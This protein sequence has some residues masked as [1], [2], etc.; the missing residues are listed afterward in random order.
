MMLRARVVF[1][2]L[3]AAAA[4]VPPAT[5][6]QHHRRGSSLS[7]IDWGRVEADAVLA[8]VG[9]SFGVI[10]TL[11]AY[12]NRRYH[13]RTRV[14]CAYCEGSGSLKCGAC[15]ATPGQVLVD[16]EAIE[17]PQ[18]GGTAKVKCVNCE[19]TG[20]AIPPQLERKTHAL[21]DEELETKL[22]Q[23]GIAALA[24]DILRQG[25]SQE[26]MEQFNLLVSRR[27]ETIARRA[28]KDQKTPEEDTDTPPEEEKSIP[29]VAGGRSGDDASEDRGDTP[30]VVKEP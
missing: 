3:T 20:L 27:A 24:G 13:A 7:A 19:A 6:Q 9:G 2:V 25:P 29:P 5:Q 23:I 26:D 14:A 4:L 21:K 17:C 11:V 12:E 28:R 22:D 1:L 18:C 30:A 8:V 10:G 15:A 16:A